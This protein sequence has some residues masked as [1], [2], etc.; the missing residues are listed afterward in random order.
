MVGFLWILSFFSTHAC[1]ITSFMYPALKTWKAVENEDR[2]N[3]NLWL[4]FW[5]IYSLIYLFETVFF[6]VVS[7]FWFYYELKLVFVLWLSLPTSQ[8][9]RNIFDRA[10]SP[11]LTQHEAAI[12]EWVDKLTPYL[13]KKALKTFRRG[14][15]YAVQKGTEMIE[16]SQGENAGMLINAPS[17]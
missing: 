3:T 17:P 10:I 15:A 9:A 5:T 6:F 13:K 16:E 4:L 7:R 12:D 2:E 14:S 1:H 11:L 8:G